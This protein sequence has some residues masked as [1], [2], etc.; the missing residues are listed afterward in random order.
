[1][2]DFIEI[3]KQYIQNAMDSNADITK[4]INVCKA[5]KSNQTNAPKIV[6]YVVDDSEEERY[7]TFQGE[8]VSNL[9]V[10]ITA[11]T[12]QMKIGAVEYS[13]QDAADK[14]SDMIRVLFQKEV[15]VNAIP[16]VLY[17]RR[18]GRTLAMPFDSGEKIYMSPVRF[19]ILIK[20]K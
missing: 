9:A 2:N 7:N 10:E 13:A 12:P 5:Y 8:Q 14:L 15:I 4:K 19:E 18:V 1:M 3:L 20:N 16:D 11:F 17:V 6:I